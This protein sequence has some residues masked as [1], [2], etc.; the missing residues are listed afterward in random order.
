MSALENLKKTTNL[1]DFSRM[2]GYKEKSL[3]YI[4]YSPQYKNKYS[5]FTIPKKNGGTRVINAPDIKLKRVQKILADYLQ[6]CYEEI[7]K[8]HVD[9]KNARKKVVHGYRKNTSIETNAYCHKNKRFIL[10]L[11]LDNFFP[12]INFGRVYGFFIKD[13]HFGLSPQIATLIAQI[14][15][16]DN[17]L[18]QGAPT[19]PII[20][21]FITK[22]LDT[23]L[24]KLAQ[25][26]NLTY[27]RY[28]DDITFS[29][30]AK[31]FP[32]EV[33]SFVDN[34]WAIG[35]ELDAI[36]SKSGFRINTNKT[37][38][39]YN[40]SRQMVTGLIVNKKVNIKREYYKKLRAQCHS[41]FNNGFFYS[42]K[43]K[44]DINALQK[45]EGRLNFIFYAKTF[46]N[47]LH[48][49]EAEMHEKSIKNLKLLTGKNKFYDNKRNERYCDVS[50]VTNLTA[51][52]NLYVQF[53]I[54]KYFIKSKNT[55]ILC[56]GKTDNIYI[57]CAV[58]K[59]REKTDFKHQLTFI[60]HSKMLR[61]LTEYVGGTEKLKTFCINYK[62]II[63]KFSKEKLPFPLIIIVDNDDA[64]RKVTAIKDKKKDKEDIFIPIDKNIK[65]MPPNLYVL[66][67]PCL[68]EA[69][70]TIIE[71]YFDYKIKNF[72]GKIFNHENQ[73]CTDTEFGKSVF[74]TQVV[75]KQRDS[76]DFSKF[77][78]LLQE[79][80]NIIND[81]SS[82]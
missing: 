31:I 1:H 42:D 22:P 9:S 21:N 3:A 26:Y 40:D 36:I 60:P 57:K 70:N 81:Y 71:D 53:L 69:G 41:L 39:H 34:Q 25:K 35:S 29:C 28:A 80:D 30:N 74:A 49:K 8:N 23:H 13:K 58:D 76:I 45:L 46:E 2:L 27:T 54:Y 64:G 75:L 51:I 38:M 68:P 77:E 61:H 82:K 7:Q 17:H 19:S 33:A 18:P 73:K 72:E 55:T 67:L 78:P 63:E 59:L 6:L 50:L 12:S 16:Y 11:D 20:S 32:T 37:R 47:N 4:L 79:I 62:N 52:H 5:S 15:C 56:E 10:N 14:V 48:K 24:L 66:T 44:S 43:D 65:F